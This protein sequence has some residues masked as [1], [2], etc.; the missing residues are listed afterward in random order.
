MCGR[1][2]KG[3]KGIFSIG[4]RGSL[5]VERDILAAWMIEKKYTHSMVAL[6]I[7]DFLSQ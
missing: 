3:T 1:S 6:H 4:A 7:L 2:L 5:A